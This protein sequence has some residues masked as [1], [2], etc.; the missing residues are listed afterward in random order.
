MTSVVFNNFG[1]FIFGLNGKISSTS[2][3]IDY[4]MTSNNDKNCAK[5][6]FDASVNLVFTDSSTKYSLLTNI[7]GYIML[8]NTPADIL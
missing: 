1:D 2:S 4:I 3:T 8:T 7:T 6:A 5:N